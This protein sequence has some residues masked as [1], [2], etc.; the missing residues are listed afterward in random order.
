MTVAPAGTLTAMIPAHG[1]GFYRLR[2]NGEK[3]GKR[4]EL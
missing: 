3:M 2:L 1:I 4:D